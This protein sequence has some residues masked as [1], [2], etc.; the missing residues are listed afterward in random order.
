MKTGLADPVYQNFHFPYF[1]G[2]RA[3]NF[4]HID[5][6]VEGLQAE[7][8]TAVPAVEMGVSGVMLARRHAVEQ[9]SSP[10][11]QTLHK[12]VFHQQFQDAIHGDAVDINNSPH[13]P[14]DL[15]GSNGRRIIPDHLHNP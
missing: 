4:F 14:K 13:H 5:V 3:L 8:G 2:K 10:S 1:A 9:A 12:V 15:L 6:E 11:A 7:H